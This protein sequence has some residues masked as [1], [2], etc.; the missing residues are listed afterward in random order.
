MVKVLV[1]GVFVAADVVR[2][3]CMLYVTASV[4]V[5]ASSVC[6]E[7]LTGS[8]TTLRLRNAYLLSSVNGKGHA[9]AH[10]TSQTSVTVLRFI[11]SHEIV[12]VLLD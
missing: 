3:T 4:A 2:D 8:S 1:L 5:D 9:H 6:I 12:L 10:E 11:R 7:Q